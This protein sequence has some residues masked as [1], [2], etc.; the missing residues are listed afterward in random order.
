MNFT[1]GNLICLMIGSLLVLTGLLSETPNMD[2][3]HDHSMQKMRLGT[4]TSVVMEYDV[5]PLCHAEL[6]HYLQYGETRLVRTECLR[7]MHIQ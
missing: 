4:A 7:H 6:V 2:R 5:P 1:N 3:V